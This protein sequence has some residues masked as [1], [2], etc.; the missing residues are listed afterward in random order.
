MGLVRVIGSGPPRRSDRACSGSCLD[1]LRG[2]PRRCLEDAASKA[3]LYGNTLLLTA[4]EKV[5]SFL[6]LNGMGENE[7]VQKDKEKAET[8]RNISE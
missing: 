3:K 5:S 7:K 6:F 2:V 4:L 8:R 1:F